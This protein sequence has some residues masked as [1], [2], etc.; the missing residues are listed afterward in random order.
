[1]TPTHSAEAK[2][3]GISNYEMMGKVGEG[4]YGVVYR[5]LHTPTQK[6]YAIKVFNKA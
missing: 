1:M 5:A 3:K 2:L 4:Q 6:L